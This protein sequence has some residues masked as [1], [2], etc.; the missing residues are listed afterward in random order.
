[1]R[2]LPEVRVIHVRRVTDRDFARYRAEGIRYLVAATEE[3]QP[4]LTRSAE[5]VGVFKPSAAHP[6]PTSM[7]FRVPAAS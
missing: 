3:S 2:L 6:G 4:R 1:M 7:V 5:I